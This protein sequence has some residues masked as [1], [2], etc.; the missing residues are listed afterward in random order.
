MARFCIVQGNTEILEID[1]TNPD[2]TPFDVTG[3]VIYFTIKQS[4]Q[5]TNED[6]MFMGSTLSGDVVVLNAPLGIIQITIPA[7]VSKTMRVGKIYYWDCVIT[8]ADQYFTPTSGE[9]FAKAG[10]RRN[11]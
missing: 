1:I 11:E 8:K 4:L 3:F 7:S 6:A 10:V 9:I 5:D 2:C